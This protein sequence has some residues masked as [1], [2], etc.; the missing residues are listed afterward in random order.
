MARPST[1]DPT[2]SDGATRL[3][4]LDQDRIVEAG[5]DPQAVTALLTRAHREIDQG[6]LP[7]CQLALAR[8]G[9]VV[10]EA[11]LGS[12]EPVDRY[13]IFSCTKAITGAAVWRLLSDGRLARAQRVAE[14]IPEFGTNGKD[15]VTVEQLL[16]HTA[17]FPLAPLGPPDWSDHDARLARYARWRLNWEPGSRFEYHPTSAHWVLA[18]LITAVTGDDYRTWIR[19]ELLDRLGLDRLLLGADPGASSPVSLD[20]RP[21][22]LVGEHPTPDEMEAALGMRI[23]LAELLGE[24]TDEAKV[25]ISEPDNLAVGVPAGGAISTAADLARFY[26]ALLHDDA[27]LWDPEILRLG[28]AEVLCDLPDPIQGYPAHRTLGLVLAGDDGHKAVRGF[29]HTA[30]PRA[31]GHGGAG[32]QIAFADPATGLSFCYLTDGH[33]RQLIREWR[34]TAGI[35]SRAAV[36]AGVPA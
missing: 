19:R 24:V 18:E 10:V 17:G 14:V 31:F 4:G 34:R 16:T 21:V 26:Q 33:E 27:G 32:G 23:D 12:A 3:P 6:L 1:V 22:R 25:A 30:S 36:C 11:T 35:A 15:V 9:E 7:S 29:G 8:D 20:A 28:T 2:S 13:V 5:L